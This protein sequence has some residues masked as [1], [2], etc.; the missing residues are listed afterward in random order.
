[1]RKHDPA[2][3]Q[4]HYT[5]NGIHLTDLEAE[6]V[7]FAIESEIA[8]PMDWKRNGAFIISWT[9]N[10]PMVEGELDPSK[11]FELSARAAARR[12]ILDLLP[13]LC[14]CDGWADASRWPEQ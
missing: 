11:G 6:K 2:T 14:R 13:D 3:L 10:R 1:M 5:V 8:I 9:G 7:A 4:F 12:T